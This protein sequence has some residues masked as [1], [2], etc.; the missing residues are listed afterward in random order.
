[1]LRHNP[2]R[3][4]YHIC[5]FENQVRHLR[6]LLDDLRTLSRM[7]RR[8][9]SLEFKVCSV[10]ALVQRVFDI[11]EPVAIN[12]HQTLTLTIDPTL[13]EIH[14]DE[15]QIERV[16]VNLVSN[17]V[18]CTLEV[19]GICLEA[20]AEDQAVVIRVIDHGMGI[21]AEDLPHCV[22]KILSHGRSA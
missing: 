1:M 6:N 10:G 22:R 11:Y 16:L 5:A 20:V 21:A 15:Q 3:L 4:E 7:D 13:P 9:M 8:Q 2:E 19:K 18:N 17:A 12:K 14:L